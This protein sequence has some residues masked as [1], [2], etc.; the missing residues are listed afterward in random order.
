MHRTSLHYRLD[1]IAG[2]TGLDLM[3]GSDRLALHLQ[4]CLEDLS[5]AGA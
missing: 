5:D 4:L 2:I 3:S 1:R